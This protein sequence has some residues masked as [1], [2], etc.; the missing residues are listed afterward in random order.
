MEPGLLVSATKDTRDRSTEEV[1]HAFGEGTWKPKKE[2]SHWPEEEGLGLEQ[3]V[4]HT[5]PRRPPFGLISE[6]KIATKLF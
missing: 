5:E 4:E 3:R 1:I 6:Q 2:K